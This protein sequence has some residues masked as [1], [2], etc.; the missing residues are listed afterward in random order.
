MKIVESTAEIEQPMESQEG[1]FILIVKDA[2]K[3]FNEGKA[4]EVRALQGA[5]FKVKKGEIVAVMGPSGSGKTTLLNLIGGLDIINDGYISIDDQEIAALSEKERTNFRL[6]NLGF[7][8]QTFNLLD[9]LTTLQNVI[10]PLTSQGISS[11]ES[12]RKAMKIL[13]ELGIGDK[14]NYYPSELSGGQNQKV[15]IARSLITRPLLILGDEPTG[16]LDLKSTDDI[17]QLFRS[18]NREKGVT[19]ILVTHSEWVGS[20]CDRIVRIDEGKIIS[21]M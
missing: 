7:I 14:A 16:D 13:R 6:D 4:N 1:D 21:E 11:T 19:M 18:I 10:L 8:F 2:Y 3:I 5:S 20:Q 15:A 12:R 9:Y 17:L